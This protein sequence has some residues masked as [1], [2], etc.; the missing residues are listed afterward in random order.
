MNLAIDEI[1]LLSKKLL[2]AS[3]QTG[4][5]LRPT[6]AVERDKLLQRYPSGT[7][8]LKHCQTQLAKS[9][10][11]SNWQHAVTV[12]SGKQEQSDQADWGCLWYCKACMA[13]SNQW[14]SRYEEA[15]GIHQQQEDSYLIGYKNQ[16][17]LVLKDY[18]NTLGLSDNDIKHIE[19]R[20]LI[21]NYPNFQWDQLAFKL[22]Q[23]R[24][25]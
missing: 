4:Q 22:I 3:K 25:Q 24:F 15:A 23:T 10:G 19:D 13:F 20:D 11:F 18:L 14:F 1:K 16:Y 12:L 6:L 2:K 5:A 8:Q 17:V 7:A 21:A 9:L